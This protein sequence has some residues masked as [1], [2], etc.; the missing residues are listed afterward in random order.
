[1]ENR[2]KLRPCGAVHPGRDRRGVRLCLLVQAGAVKPRIARPIALSLSARCPA[3]P[4]GVVRFNGLRVGEVTTIE[5]MPADPGKVIATIEI[6]RQTP[7]RQDT[8]GPPR[9]SGPDRRRFVQLTGGAGNSP[10]LTTAD[11]FCRPLL[12]ADRSDYQ[13]ILETVQRLSSKIDT[14]LTRAD[15]LPHPERRIGGQYDKNVEAFSKALADNSS[16]VSSFPRQ[17][18]RDEPEGWLAVAA[19]RAVCRSGGNRSFG[20]GCQ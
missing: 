17:C 14:V 10:P 16:G 9:I 18:R 20:R 6:D 3:F 11:P 7:I 19:D 13:D 15:G 1:M 2:A 4:R 8:P 5:I 12:F